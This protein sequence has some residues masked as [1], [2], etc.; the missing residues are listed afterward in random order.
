MS[1]WAP[2]DLELGRNSHATNAENMTRS[3]TVIGVNEI[4]PTANGPSGARNSTG[5]LRK[6][7]RDSVFIP[8]ASLLQTAKGVEAALSIG[9]RDSSYA[10]GREGKTDLRRIG[11]GDRN[12]RRPSSLGGGLLAGKFQR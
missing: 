11:E 12:H 6:Y 4:A 3:E 5:S 10:T 8:V 7:V 9:G 2:E 1:F